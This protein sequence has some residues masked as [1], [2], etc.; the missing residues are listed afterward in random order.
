GTFRSGDGVAVLSGGLGGEENFLKLRNW[1][2]RRI[3]G[4]R[5]NCYCSAGTKDECL[6]ATEIA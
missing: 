5:D 3:R 2:K 6:L 1:G 4:T